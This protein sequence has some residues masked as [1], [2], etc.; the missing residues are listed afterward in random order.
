VS[1]IAARFAKLRAENRAA[2]A[3][4]ITAGDPD[5]A[6]SASILAGL[7]DA[8]ADVIEL[9]MPFSDPMADGATIQ[10]AGLRALKA[11]MTLKGVLA[12]VAAFRKRDSETPVVLMGYLNPIFSYGAERFAR[13]AAASGVDGLIIV[14]VPPEEAQEIA[15]HAAA[16]GL[17]LIRLAT[18][19]S[20]AARLPRVVAGASG[21][22]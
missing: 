19:T 4:F 16:Y 21:F 9:G 18:P 20:D 12:M 3:T 13:D 2:L 6:T 10:A 8:G 11:G 15:P 22:I 14:D 1:R 7:A 17:D 5:A